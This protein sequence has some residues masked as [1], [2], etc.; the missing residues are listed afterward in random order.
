MSS[1]SGNSQAVQFEEDHFGLF[2]DRTTNQS[3]SVRRF[4]WRNNDNIT[5]QLITYGAT[6]TSIKLPDKS[7]KI[8][9]IVLGFDDVEGKILC[10]NI[11]PL[12]TSDWQRSFGHH[13]ANSTHQ[14]KN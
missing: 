4:T 6:I 9:D 14:Y 11:F 1:K 10:N 12:S 13:S 8:E 2:T 5:V 7:G 3:T